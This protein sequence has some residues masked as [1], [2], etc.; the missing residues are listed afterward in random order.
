MTIP[1]RT[2]R[3]Q[4][5]ERAEQRA[6]AW[7]LAILDRKR[8]T[9]ER[10]RQGD[11]RSCGRGLGCNCDPGGP[12]AASLAVVRYAFRPFAD[13]TLDWSRDA[14][15]DAAVAVTRRRLRLAGVSRRRAEDALD[16]FC[17]APC[18]ADDRSVEAWLAVNE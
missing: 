10:R 16:A 12:E 2:I 18:A 11:C 6:E 1:N 14:T 13:M 5:R 8:A 4:R 17:F 15:Y 3:R 9:W 7:A